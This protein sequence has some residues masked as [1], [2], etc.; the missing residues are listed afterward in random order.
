MCLQILSK[1]PI[2]RAVDL[3]PEEIEGWAIPPGAPYLATEALP[4][5]PLCRSGLSP[6]ERLGAWLFM[7]ECLVAFRR[8]ELVYTDVKC[9]N[10]LV[11]RKSKTMSVID[12]GS[13]VVLPQIHKFRTFAHTDGFQAPE[14]ITGLRAS[15]ATLV[16]QTAATLGCALVGFK[17]TDPHRRGHGVAALARSLSERGAPGLGALV[18][19][20]LDPDPAVRPKNYE[21]LLE[22]AV[23]SGIPPTARRFWRQLRRPSAEA[24]EEVGLLGP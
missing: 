13:M 2:P 8:H 16:Y 11:D 22:A 23:R 5:G 21:D 1:F 10:V 14:Q 4:G 6:M 24:L 17:S 19:R 9:Y 20:S 12:F 15:E 3:N 18:R 7:V